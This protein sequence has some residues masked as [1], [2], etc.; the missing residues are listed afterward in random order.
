MNNYE[1]IKAMSLDEMAE[2]LSHFQCRRKAKEFLETE[3]QKY[4]QLHYSMY[5][6]Y[7]CGISEHPQ[8]Q[9]DKLGYKVIGA[10]AQSLTD[11]WWFTVEEYIEPLP[12]Y[13]QKFE[14][15]YFYWHGDGKKVVC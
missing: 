1:K 5:T 3:Y 13:L 14:Y 8:A 6:A 4:K 7:D 9:M 10:V 2:F 12:P 15:D 11:S